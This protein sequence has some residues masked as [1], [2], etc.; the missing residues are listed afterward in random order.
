MN[1]LIRLISLETST[2]LSQFIEGTVR[3]R[4]A[5][6]S[7]EIDEVC[8]RVSD[9]NGPRG[10][11]D[12]QCQVTVRGRA[13]ASFHVEELGENSYASVDLA[14]TRAAHAVK[15]GLQRSRRSRKESSVRRAFA[16][17]G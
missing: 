14:V 2:T 17:T 1:V 5:R 10:G 7:H 16:M 3:Q 8:V 15:R 13:V 4:F 12:K 6:L 11:L 9:V